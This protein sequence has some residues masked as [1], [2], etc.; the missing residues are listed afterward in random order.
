[1][2]YSGG[3]KYLSANA[4]GSIEVSSSEEPDN[5]PIEKLVC[6]FIETGNPII[7]L[8]VVIICVGFASLRRFKK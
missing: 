5:G 1:M 3:D 6:K 2:F 4:T 7:V 8:L